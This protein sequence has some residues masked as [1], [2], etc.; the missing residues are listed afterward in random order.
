[1]LLCIQLALCFFL[2]HDHKLPDQC[3]LQSVQ[4]AFLLLFRLKCNSAGLLPV[5]G[6]M[7][8]L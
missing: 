7:M 2:C 1:V 8:V 4:A 3:A 6:W 5:V